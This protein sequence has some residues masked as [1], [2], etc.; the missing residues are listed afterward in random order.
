MD[1]WI[2]AIMNDKL[3]KKGDIVLVGD[4]KPLSGLFMGKYFTH[5]LLYIGSNKCIHAGVTTGVRKILF[6]KIFKQYDTCMILR[7]NIKNYYNQVIEEA[8]EFA[9]RQIGKPFD[10]F[11][12]DNDDSYF[13]TN[14][15]NCSFSSAGFDTGIYN[16]K[17]KKGFISLSYMHR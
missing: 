11:L 7:P 8:I 12:E 14:L 5:S 9:Q 4:F 16:N 1:A 3:I 13:C 6:K 2:Y 10:F 17:K 15:I